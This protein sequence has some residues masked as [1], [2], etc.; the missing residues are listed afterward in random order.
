M[1]HKVKIITA[2]VSIFLATSACSQIN[3]FLNLKD[4]N[5]FEE[6]V[7]DI[8]DMETGLKID[9]TPED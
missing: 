4:D 8:I 5:I 3:K 9:L 7:E 1:I 2:L 6:F